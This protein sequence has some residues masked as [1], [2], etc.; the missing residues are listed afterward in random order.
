MK[1][2]LVV[3]DEYGSAQIVRLLLEAEGYRVALAGNGRAALELLAGEAPALI[4]SDF[5]MPVMN[6]GELGEAV[7]RDPA[8]CQIPFVIMSGTDEEIVRRTFRGY[9][10]F[11]V[12]PF[13]MDPL[14]SLIKRLVTNGRPPQPSS[15]AIGASMKQLMRGIRLPGHSD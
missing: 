5:M 3:E 1:F 11:L 4:L 10:A 7:R 13:E 2:I 6:G 9:D 15:E 12:K 8:L 14:L